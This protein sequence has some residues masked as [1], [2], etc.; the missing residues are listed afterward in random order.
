MANIKLKHKH[1]KIPEEV[2]SSL[3]TGYSGYDRDWETT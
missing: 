2:L 3:K 1:F